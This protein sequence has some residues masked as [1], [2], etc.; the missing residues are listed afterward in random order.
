MKGI[1]EFLAMFS[2]GKLFDLVRDIFKSGVAKIYVDIVEGLRNVYFL[3]IASIAIVLLVFTGFLML[4]AALF[5]YL[6]WELCDKLFLMLAL[7]LSY[8]LVPLIAFAVLQ[9]RS[10]WLKSSGAQK[11]IDD[12]VNKS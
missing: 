9:S 7:G 4:H 2:L 5:L 6:P 11:F 8:I 3:L 10:R 12:I 1:F